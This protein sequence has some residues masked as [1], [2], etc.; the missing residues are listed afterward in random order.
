[1]AALFEFDPARQAAFDEW[2]ASRPL[3]IQSLVRRLPPNRLY[4]HKKSGHRMTIVSYAENGTVTATVSGQYNFCVFEREVFGI[5]VDDLE[6]CDLPSP[7]EKLGA[8]L[9]D[10][11]DVEAFIDAV[12]PAVLRERAERN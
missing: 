7:D 10:P 4:R 11:E 3:H 6:E 5:P 8:V 9:T 2:L 12:R 1:M